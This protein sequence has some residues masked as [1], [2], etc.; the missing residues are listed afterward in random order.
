MTA[1]Q[2][3]ELTLAEL[4]ASA[5]LVHCAV[6]KTLFSEPVLLPCLHSFCVECLVGLL[7]DDG[8]ADKTHYEAVKE[9]SLEDSRSPPPS[10]DP[11][12]GNS[13]DITSIESTEGSGGGVRALKDKDQE[14][15]T[16]NKDKKSGIERTKA[17]VQKTLESRNCGNDTRLDLKN[18]KVLKGRQALYK[19][20]KRD[21]DGDKASV[22]L[23]LREIEGRRP[24]PGDRCP[25]TSHQAKAARTEPSATTVLSSNQAPAGPTHISTE[26]AQVKPNGSTASNRLSVLLQGKKPQ[27]SLACPT[28]GHTVLLAGD[29]LVTD[30]DRIDSSDEDGGSGEEVKQ[31]RKDLKGALQSQQISA[32]AF[33]SSLRRETMHGRTSSSKS[34][35]TQKLSILIRKII[36]TSLQHNHFLNSLAKINRCK[37]TNSELHLKSGKKK[38]GLDEMD[39]DDSALVGHK[40]PKEESFCAYCRTENQEVEA[41]SMC[42]DCNDRVCDACACAHRKTRVT[43]EHTVAPLTS[44]R[45]GLFD[46]DLRARDHVICECHHGMP[47]SIFCCTCSVA[48]CKRCKSDQHR[49]HQVMSLRDATEKFVPEV[50]QIQQAIA[51]RVP[52][53]SDYAGF[54]EEQMS[55][56][57]NTRKLVA[58]DVCSQAQLLHMMVEEHKQKLL[59]RLEQAC[60][61][62]ASDISAILQDTL[63]ARDALSDT[64]AFLFH[65]WRLGRA[66]E[67]LASYESVVSY[68]KHLVNSAME[69]HNSTPQGKQPAGGD[70]PNSSQGSETGESAI[71]AAM[72]QSPAT[73]GANSSLTTRLA[74]V[75]TAGPCTD[76]NVKILLGPLD[77]HRVPIKAKD[78]PK[79]MMPLTTLLPQRLDTPCVQHTFHAATADDRCPVYPSGIALHPRLLA[80]ADRENAVV[81]IFDRVS[82]KFLKSI[83]GEGDST[84]SKPFDVV[85]LDKTGTALAVSDTEASA[86][87]VF[88]T[89][90][91]KFLFNFGGGIRHPRGMTAVPSTG[92]VVVVDGHLRHLTYHAAATGKMLR[93]IRPTLRPRVD[94]T[95]SFD[96]DKDPKGRVKTSDTS[97]ATDVDNND[98]SRNTDQSKTPRVL[99]GETD[100]HFKST[101]LIDPYYVSVALSGDLAVTDLASPNLKLVSTEGGAVL[102]QSMD[103]GT[104]GEESLHPSGLCVD[105]YGQI[106][107][108]DTNNNRIHLA[109]P[110]G[111]LTGTTLFCK[112]NTKEQKTCISSQENYT[113]KDKKITEKKED[114]FR[115]PTVSKPLSLAI[116][117]E[118]GYLVVAQVGGEIKFIKYM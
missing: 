72:L 10:A 103:Y 83:A 40:I 41:S 19:E 112:E 34:P 54:L 114:D 14:R 96:K 35:S 87:L 97:D 107:I 31:P 68:Y 74:C 56:L 2:P 53:L 111:Q 43:R 28:C 66:D 84:L 3:A 73:P 98:A 26:Q 85:F 86:V 80:V 75:F 12:H 110:N 105:N 58:S 61:E 30:D 47:V 17:Y 79:V 99:A 101:A 4:L 92:E 67:I 117:S 11:H 81:K 22:K 62:Q 102:S 46:H 118:T 116:D 71:T 9:K 78:N 15:L 48:V 91:G 21:G 27:L 65:L 1:T 25:A 13:T 20:S 82:G 55:K 49:S 57:D 77:L 93:R 113:I 37:A 76:T 6:C 51:R 106:F 7:L 115:R 109:L 39:A 108:S 94:T 88:E 64:W 5:T 8:K 52:S 32:T 45:Q 95:H 16:N 60:T 69:L 18:D 44:I 36:R 104:G 38:E 63:R 29:V 89:L 100:M 90:T 33:N 70:D 42:L 59:S 50:R 23:I 24:G